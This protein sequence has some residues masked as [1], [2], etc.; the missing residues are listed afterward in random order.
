[1]TDQ[2]EG[3][4]GGGGG[5]TTTAIELN[6]GGVFYTTGL[7]TL[8]KEPNSRLAELFR[9]RLATLERDAKGRY[10][11]DRDGVLFRYVLDFLRNQALVLPEGFRERERLRQ[12]ASFYGLASLE[13]AID[14]PTPA[15]CAQ[16]RD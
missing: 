14:Q 6:V 4:G 16:V 5:G 9:D 15:L 7:G 1:M 13:R 8:T 11:L 3:G 10:F 12:E 2:E